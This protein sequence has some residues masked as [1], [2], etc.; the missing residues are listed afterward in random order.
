MEFRLATAKVNASRK[1]DRDIPG[2]NYLANAYEPRSQ[3]CVSFKRTGQLEFVLL[4][5]EEFCECPTFLPNEP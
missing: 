5:F 2:N 3:L 4:F 1:V